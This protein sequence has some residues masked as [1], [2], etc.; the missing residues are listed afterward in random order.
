MHHSHPPQDH[1][2]ALHLIEQNPGLN[3]LPLLELV[4]QETSEYLEAFCNHAIFT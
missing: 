2:K 1:I 4:V 3:V